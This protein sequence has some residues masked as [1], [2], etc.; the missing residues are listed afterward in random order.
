MDFYIH[1]EV[2]LC[3]NLKNPEQNRQ[4][5]NPDIS[6]LRGV[7]LLGIQGLAVA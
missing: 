3:P 7:H 6:R 1:L 2:F 4:Q 5:A